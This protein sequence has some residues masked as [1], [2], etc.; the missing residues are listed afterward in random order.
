[1]E[2][3]S[4]TITITLIISA[5]ILGVSSKRRNKDRCLNSFDKSPVTIE[6][7]TGEIIT[8][9]VL[10]V[11]TTGLEIKYPE[12]IT[13]PKGFSLSSYLLYKYEF[14][15]IQAII[16]PQVEL[17]Q[18]GQKKR[19]KKLE[20]SNRPNLFRKIIRKTRNL[21]NSLKDSFLE[22]MNISMNYL[23]SKKSSTLLAHDKYVRTINS[24]LL[25]SVGLSHEP[26][27]EPYIGHIV[28]VEY[29]KEKEKIKLRGILSDYTKEFLL[30]MNVKYQIP[31]ENE[32]QIVDMIIPQKLAIVR[33]LGTKIPYKF[34]FLKE[35]KSFTARIYKIESKK[36]QKNEKNKK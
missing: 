32:P 2:F 22:V 4:L 19:D 31:G 11:R 12:V 23:S 14:P 36:E 10:K 34:P 26:L 16:R 8:K 13:T 29:I 5:V 7:I 28:V 6:K 1:M 9:G 30:L 24:E 15:Q 35:I 3:N 18:K 21:F 27:L 20:S 33:H 17:S 25:E